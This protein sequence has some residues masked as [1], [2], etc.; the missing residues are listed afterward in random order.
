MRR[1]GFDVTSKY[2]KLAKSYDIEL[3]S[4]G[5]REF[6]ENRIE[7]R[8]RCFVALHAPES[9]AFAIFDRTLKYQGFRNLR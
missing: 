7:V 1:V 3:L 9:T 4:K 8:G 5:N 6:N 2:R